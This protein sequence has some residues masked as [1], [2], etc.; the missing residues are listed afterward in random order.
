MR[1]HNATKGVFLLLLLMITFSKSSDL[2]FTAKN[3][4]G[5]S[6][7]N[8]NVT[9][10][11]NGTIVFGGNSSNVAK[12]TISRTADF[13][14]VPWRNFDPEKFKTID[15]NPDTLYVK[16]M[17]NR[18]IVSNIIVYTPRINEG[19]VLKTSNN[20]DVYIIKYKNNKQYKRLILSPSVFDSYEH[21]KWSN[22]KI[23]SQGV[24]D[25]YVTSNLVQVPGD[26][27]IYKLFPDGDK[28][29]RIVFNTANSYDPDSVYQINS[30]DRDSYTWVGYSPTDCS[31]PS[32]Q[33][34]ATANGVGSQ[35]RV[36]NYGAW[37]NWDAC[38]PTS[39]N[40]GY[41]INGKVCVLD[42][43]IPIILDFSIPATSP[44][45]T[46]AIPS[47]A[48]TDNI[49]VTG[50]ALT[51]SSSK[52]PLSAFSSSKPTSYTFSSYGTKNLYAWAM[53][54]A[55][56]ISRYASDSIVIGSSS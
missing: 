24:L 16:F 52:P 38:V 15:Q 19:D 5:S 40:S 34:C 14:G 27:N 33:T 50:Y 37:S 7:Y 11:D 6:V 18:G 29:E 48:A 44:S 17:T 36:C 43:D 30:T 41:W 32:V 28:G 55:G 31:G 26:S 4:F 20:P 12:I 45:L 42:T 25:Q 46:I 9:V 13:A 10:L 8:T 56:N 51:E 49:G 21:L 39:C 23:V 53:D 2:F 47:F 22:I 1:T 35:S 54:A 3:C